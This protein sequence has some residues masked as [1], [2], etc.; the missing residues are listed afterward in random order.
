[1]AKKTKK[2]VKVTKP[3]VEILYAYGYSGERVK[4]CDLGDYMTTIVDAVKDHPDAETAF[5]PIKGLSFAWLND[6]MLYFV[7]Y[8]RLVKGPVSEKAIAEA[9][10]AV[11]EE[12]QE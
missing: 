9:T 3:R 5:V 12:D 4:E 7:A 8:R 1:M 2:P 11:L 10:R 6:P